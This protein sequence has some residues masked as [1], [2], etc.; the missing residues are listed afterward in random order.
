M[1][2]MRERGGIRVSSSGLSITGKIRR[3]RSV[4]GGMG[5]RL[6]GEWEGVGVVVWVGGQMGEGEREESDV[7]VWGEVGEPNGGLAA[8]ER[9]RERSPGGSSRPAAPI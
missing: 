6:V 4:G 9:E 1:R 7:C 5:G 8:N 3:E 2:D